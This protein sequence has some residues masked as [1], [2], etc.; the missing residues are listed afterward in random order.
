[1]YISTITNQSSRS[2]NDILKRISRSIG[3]LNTSANLRVGVMQPDY[4]K[5]C[6]ENAEE[7]SERGQNGEEKKQDTAATSPG[8]SSN[9]A[10]HIKRF[11]L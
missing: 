11:I 3:M 8:I 4:A 6:N 1:M 5:P 2:K 10:A 9:S 7:K